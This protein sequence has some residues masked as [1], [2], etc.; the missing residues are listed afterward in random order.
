MSRQIVEENQQVPV[1]H[2]TTFQARGQV[3]GEREA[4]EA[5]GTEANVLNSACLAPLPAWSLVAAPA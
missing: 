5:E 4:E 3:L 2:L 1:Q